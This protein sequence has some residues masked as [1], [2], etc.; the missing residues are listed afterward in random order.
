M[1]LESCTLPIDY[2]SRIY[3]SR[4]GILTLQA[5][6]TSRAARLSLSMMKDVSPLP[7]RRKEDGEI[8]ALYN[9]EEGAYLP[10]VRYSGILYV[11]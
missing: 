6:K 11:R 4:D 5:M 8:R 2:R 1:F 9:A 10:K 7:G 3:M